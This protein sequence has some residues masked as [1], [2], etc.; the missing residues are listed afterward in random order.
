METLIL[1]FQKNFSILLGLFVK[2]KKVIISHWE[3]LWI[4]YQK[5]FSLWFNIE[6]VSNTII[7]MGNIKNQNIPQ[8]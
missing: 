5:A 4:K 7:I 3:S 6:K 8:V 2:K 1:L